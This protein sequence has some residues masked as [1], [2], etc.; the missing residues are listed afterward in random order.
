MFSRELKKALDADDQD[1]ITKGKEMQSYI[2]E[3]RSLRKE[4]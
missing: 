2:E 1:R 3:C 4:A